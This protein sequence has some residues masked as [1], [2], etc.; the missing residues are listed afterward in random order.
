MIGHATPGTWLITPTPIPDRPGRTRYPM[1]KTIKVRLSAG[2]HG[3]AP[4]SYTEVVNNDT[5]VG[6]PGA[7]QS[8]H[9]SRGV[10]TLTI[11]DPRH[12]LHRG[13]TMA[14]GVGPLT[15]TGLLLKI[16]SLSRDG[17]IA[18]VTG[19]QGTL[20]DIGPQG[21]LQTQSTIT[22]PSPPA[23]TARAA[24]AGEDPGD[25]EE[26]YSCSNGA[27]ASISG[28]V[29]FRSNVILHGSWGGFWHPLTIKA[30][31][32][33]D[34]VEQSN[35]TLS[36]SGQATCK[37]EKELLEKPIKYDPIELWVGPVPVVIVPELNFNV[38]VK[39]S[40]GASL[41]EEVSQSVGMGVG[42][43]WDGKHLNGARWFNRSFTHSPFTPGVT[44]SLTGS[45][46]PELDFLIY[47][48]AGPYLSADGNV[49]LDVD[50][51]RTPW[52]QLT[53][54][55]EAGL[56]LKFKFFGH[57][58]DKGIP[59]V[60]SA[61][62][63]IAQAST[64]APPAITT[65]SLPNGTAG[66]MYAAT[67]ATQHGAMPFQWSVS[68]GTLPTGLT[69]NSNTG[70]ITG[71]PTTPGGYSF[72]LTV[73]DRDGQTGTHAYTVVIAPPPVVIATQSLPA[74]IV[75]DSYS[76]TLTTSSGT[77]PYQWSV[78]SGSLPAG[79]TL[80]P[81]SGTISGTP[82]TNGTS[83][84]TIL[85]TDSENQNNTRSFTITINGT[86]LPSNCSR[87]GTT[88]TCSY[89]DTGS[90]QTFTAPTGVSSVH[91]VAVGA[92]GQ[93]FSRSGGDGA[94]VTGDLS[95]T[96]GQT[97]FVEIGVGGGAG[98]TVN[99]GA[100]GGESDVRTCSVANNSCPALG[101]AQDPRLIVAGGGG[102]SG[103]GGGAGA[104]GNAVGSGATATCQ[105]GAAGG[106]T[107]A[108]TEISGG[109]GGAS[110]MTGGAAG[111]AISGGGQTG[112]AGTA[113]AGGAGGGTFNG[114]GGGGAGYYGGGGGGGPTGGGTGSGGGGGG[115]SSFGPSGSVFA[116][117]STGTPSVTISYTAPS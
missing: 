73:T 69:L 43:D 55:I 70:A 112:H 6:N 104:G 72:T 30:H 113:G 7:V 31:F 45:I 74:G 9:E 11:P 111:A 89:S 23:G 108:G 64:P 20:S 46:G 66:S 49:S 61:N 87:S 40:V 99:A 93:A 105:P 92:T 106:N 65:A 24:A 29:S 4:V 79:L 94:Q 17:Q 13:S 39:G 36:V 56:G 98:A 35:L 76:T 57:E 100:G 95:V 27:S 16:T 114:G 58:F 60:L 90:E 91:V 44:A 37:F 101:S 83:A 8:L 62:W 18:H 5:A 82:T 59:D 110:C 3:T 75:G 68:Q 81:S 71:T 15:P 53:A 47:G 10:F 78:Q 21:E 42:L 51:T 2:A 12:S 25:F 85:V 48:G 32:E 107:A 86:A 88:V 19:T 115:G 96:D 26:P 1:D 77:P 52:W 38:S 80:D 28:G 33:V 84:F 117:A 50:T 116:A 63:T 102:G 67:P 109:G 97:L 54:G 14:L 41:T 103:V 34:G 22:T